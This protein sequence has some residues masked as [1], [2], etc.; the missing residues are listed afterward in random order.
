MKDYG[1]TLAADDWI[2]VLEADCAR[3]TDWLRLLLRAALQ[4]PEME[5]VSGLTNYAE[6]RSYKRVLNLLDRS[7]NDSGSSRPC[8]FVSNNGALYRATLLRQ[9]PFEDAS[10]PFLSARLR[11][12]KMM[13]SGHK[14]YFERTAVI[15]HAVGELSFIRDYR[16]NL[17]HMQM[18][19]KERRSLARI[20]ALMLKN[21]LGDLRRYRWLGRLYLRLWDLGLGAILIFGIRVPEAIGI[22]HAVRN[23]RALP[24]TAHRKARAHFGARVG[25]R[26][27]APTTPWNRIEYKTF[28][29]LLVS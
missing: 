16:M 29:I 26:K 24:G 20:P 19:L 11:N 8:S 15:R 22:Y 12:R 4:H 13:A 2:A 10:T 17:G 23:V 28:R 9:F 1:V 21:R 5:A 25:L 14:F 3:A 27:S 18:V 7:F 6:E